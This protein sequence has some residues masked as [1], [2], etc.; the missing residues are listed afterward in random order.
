MLVPHHRK[1]PI[2]GIGYTPHLGFWLQKHPLFR[3]FLGKSSRDYGQQIPS[4]PEKMGN[5]HAT[6]LCIR[7]GGGGG[8]R[9]GR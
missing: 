2:S 6:P 5:M 9:R 1:P 3:V 4:F 7:V 8:E